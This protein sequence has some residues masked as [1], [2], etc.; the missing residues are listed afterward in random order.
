VRVDL[1]DTVS[2]LTLSSNSTP[3]GYNANNF[4][5]R[6]QN[7]ALTPNVSESWPINVDTYLVEA[8]SISGKNLLNAT[9]ITIQVGG[10]ALPEFQFKPSLLLALLL[11]GAT[12]TVASR[13]K[14]ADSNGAL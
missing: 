4:S 6:V 7:V 13:R 5:V 3:V 14:K 12:L 11:T 1:V 10:N 9:T 2:Q 8:G